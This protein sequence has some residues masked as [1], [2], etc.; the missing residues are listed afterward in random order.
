[1]EILTVIVG[2]AVIKE[3]NLI[4]YLGYLL[5]TLTAINSSTGYSFSLISIVGAANHHDSDGSILEKTGVYVIAPPS[6]KAGKRH[7]FKKKDNRQ[8]ELFAA[9]G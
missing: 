5:H 9:A 7:K 1:M 2:N 4:T 6:E 8:K 3:I